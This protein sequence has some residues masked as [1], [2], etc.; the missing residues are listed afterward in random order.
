LTIARFKIRQAL[1][2]GDYNQ[3]NQEAHDYI[4][5]VFTVSP[6]YITTPL[7]KLSII[8]LLMDKE[9]QSSDTESQYITVEEIQSYFEPCGLSPTIIRQHLAELLKYRLVEP[10]DPTDKNVYEDQRVRITHCGRIHYEFALRDD[11]YVTS[12]ALTTGVRSGDLIAVL[13]SIRSRRMDRNDWREVSK[14]FI[15]H[16]L[17]EDKTFV[18]IPTHSAYKGQLLLRRGLAGAWTKTYEE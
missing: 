16:V 8:S 15:E 11:V 13:R 18:S 10:Y 3:F 2:F 1:I 4:L 14:E 7:T 12:M 9:S 6:E 17:S 5:N